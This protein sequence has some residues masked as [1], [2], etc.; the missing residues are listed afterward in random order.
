MSKV[1][2]LVGIE[3]RDY[4]K[5]GEQRHF[6]NLHFCHLEGTEVE[7]KGCKVQALRCPR[8][9]DDRKLK[10]GQTYELIYRTYHTK[11]QTGNPIEA[12]YFAAVLEVDG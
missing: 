11:D 10:L 5:D 12:Q 4:M 6:C 9:V 2:K 8:E 7:V 1:A 3:A